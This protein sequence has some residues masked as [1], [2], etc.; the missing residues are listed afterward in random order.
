[1]IN[2]APLEIFAIYDCPAG[3][4][5]AYVVRRWLIVAGEPLADWRPLAVTGSLA[6]AR[7]AVPVRA[8]ARIIRCPEDEPQLVETWL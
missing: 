4:P 5:D 3:H 6:E 1:M 8:N 7:E 2:A